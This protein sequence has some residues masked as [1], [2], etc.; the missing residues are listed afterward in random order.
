[1]ST[2]GSGGAGMVAKLT[3]ELVELQDRLR[4]GQKLAAYFESEILKGGAAATQYAASLAKANAVMA[5]QQAR[6][7]EIQRALGPAAGATRDT[8]R[9]LMEF[10]RAAEDAQYGVSG[11]LNN[12]PSLVQALGGSAG[13][14]GAIS[15]AVVAG[16]QLVKHWG[17]LMD[18]FGAGG[19]KTEAE[20]MEELAKA[21]EKT[22]EQEKELLAYQEK[23]AAIERQRKGQPEAERKREGAVAKAIDEGPREEILK[24]L[25]GSSAAAG[26]RVRE[27]E[28]K[29]APLEA[30]AARLEAA[31]DAGRL[32]P[33]ARDE[34]D[35]LR[36]QANKARADAAKI[37]RAEAEDLLASAEKDPKKMAELR[38]RIRQ[39]QGAFPEGLGARLDRADPAEV[40][41]REQRQQDQ[42]MSKAIAD[43]KK[44]EEADRKQQRDEERR[45]RHA[46]G[47]GELAA[48][49]DKRDREKRDRERLARDTEAEAKRAY[50]E[51]GMNA[52]DMLR[53]ARAAGQSDAEAEGAVAEAISRKLTDLGFD[54]AAI[55]D[56][57]VE[58]ASD[59]AVAVRGEVGAARA[60]P[61][62]TFKELNRVALTGATQFGADLLMAGAQDIGN[63]QLRELEQI[64]TILE[65]QADGGGDVV[66]R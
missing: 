24:A 45:L 54:P 5:Q 57:A 52:R 56:V 34:I 33:E 55:A 29:A 36:E 64:R 14:T 7:G 62:G 20:R 37:N 23:R 42:E 35:R 47:Q 3:Q 60:D 46:K 63:K 59:A 6:V 44:A 61:E 65:R 28:A 51:M 11:V 31:Q 40:A 38:G 66:L 12:I 22:V 16:Y 21:T 17:D 13:L 2:G 4:T 53:A 32:G 30:K 8:G 43:G 1:M 25:M 48:E 27:A 9:A 15:L 58:A 41:R 50:P 10:S 26:A 19:T 39:N 18:A 49:K